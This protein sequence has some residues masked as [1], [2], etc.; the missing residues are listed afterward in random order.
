MEVTEEVSLRVVL[1]NHL[2]R[3]QG[4]V[5]A[6]DLFGSMGFLIQPPDTEN[7]MSGGVGFLLPTSMGTG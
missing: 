7:R 3:Y 1:Y 2:L 5:V 6:D 4:V